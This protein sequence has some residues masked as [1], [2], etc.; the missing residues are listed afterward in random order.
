[1]RNSETGAIYAVVAPSSDFGTGEEGG[2]GHGSGH[3]SGHGRGH[4]SGSDS[5][6][7]SGSGHGSGSSDIGGIKA[8]KDASSSKACSRLSSR[9]Q[10]TVAE[11]AGGCLVGWE[12][13]CIQ[14]R[15]GHR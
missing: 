2:S 14:L 6:H 5:K 1:M 15:M 12:A 7:G 3:D 10:S 13:P 4:G 8:E 9:A 11:D